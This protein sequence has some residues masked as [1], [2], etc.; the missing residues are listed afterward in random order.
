MNS[1]EII[2]RLEEESLLNVEEIEYKDEFKV[3]KFTYQFDKDELESAKSYAIDESD[4]DVNSEECIIQSII[5]Y[6][7][8]VCIDNVQD[9]VEEIAEDEEATVQFIAYDMDF[10]DYTYCDFLAVFSE[11]EFDIDDILDDFKI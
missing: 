2:D 6:L 3:F 10:N 7:Q 9:I 11:D 5:P 4:F 8:D 1:K